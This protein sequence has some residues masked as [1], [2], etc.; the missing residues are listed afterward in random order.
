MQFWFVFFCFVILKMARNLKTSIRLH[1]QP[2][3]EFDMKLVISDVKGFL[4]ETPPSYRISQEIDPSE[5]GFSATASG[6]FYL[7]I[8]SKLSDK[9]DG[10]RTVEF[11][12]LSSWIKAQEDFNIDAVLRYYLIKKKEPI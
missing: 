12:F 1:V 3:A 4:A 8:S 7:K 6:K 9:F 10:Q 2:S 5:L 11:Q